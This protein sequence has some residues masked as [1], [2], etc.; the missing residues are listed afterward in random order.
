MCSTGTAVEPLLPVATVVFGLGVSDV[1]AEVPTGFVVLQVAVTVQLL[2]P[3]AM[4][5]V[6]GESVSVP[7]GGGG[8]AAHMLPFQLVPVVQLALAVRL[9]SSFPLL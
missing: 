4:V 9:A 8:G 7:L 3:A 1:I 6:V 5:H 2:A